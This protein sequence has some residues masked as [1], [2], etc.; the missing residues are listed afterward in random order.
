MSYTLLMVMSLCDVFFNCH[1]FFTTEVLW[2]V[3]FDLLYIV[4]VDPDGNVLHTFDGDV[5]MCCI[6]NCQP[7]F[8][9]VVLWC[10]SFDLH[11]RC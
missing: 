1:P 7:Y 6:F 4:D 3:S 10:V 5:I 11:C 9:P 8:T 2:C